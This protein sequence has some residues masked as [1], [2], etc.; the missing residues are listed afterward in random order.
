MCGFVFVF[1]MKLLEGKGPEH[2]GG[3][4]RGMEISDE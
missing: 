4:K 1:R 2:M 3:K